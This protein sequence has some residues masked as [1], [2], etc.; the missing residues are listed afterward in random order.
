MGEVHKEVEEGKNRSD[1]RFVQRVLNNHVLPLLEARGYPV[2]GGK[3]VFPKAAEQLTVAD[4]V[5][6]S[7]IMPIPQSYLHEK[8]SIPVP[9]N[10]EP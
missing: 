4:I 8:Y 5:Q 7:D 9:E 6:L 3:F 10:G 1:M 2:N